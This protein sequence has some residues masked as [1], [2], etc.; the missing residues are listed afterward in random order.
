MFDDVEEEIERAES[1]EAAEREVSER[2][3]GSEEP[4]RRLRGLVNQLANAFL[5][6][7]GEGCGAAR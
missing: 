5:A 3:E 1:V 7:V 4:R 2:A 6:D